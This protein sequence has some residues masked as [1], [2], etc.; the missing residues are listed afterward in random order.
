MTK[1]TQTVQE[2]GLTDEL[3]DDLNQH[4]NHLKQ[5]LKEMLTEI[6]KVQRDSIR[7]EVAIEAINYLDGYEGGIEDF[8][9]DL[10]NHGCAGGM[11][12]SLIYYYDTHAFF[13]KYYDEIEEMRFEYEDNTGEW[14]Q[15]KG[16]DMMN[17][18]AWLSF[19]ETAMN[20]ALELGIEL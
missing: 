8:F 9:K 4:G 17:F 12:G 20:L 19:E 6:S 1:T 3:M 10:S 7:K 5:D 15:P 2:Q 18:F 13:N 14:L 11:V 16:E